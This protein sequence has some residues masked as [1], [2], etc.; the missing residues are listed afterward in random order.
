MLLGSTLEEARQKVGNI[1]SFSELGEFASHPVRTYSSGMRARL[2]FS[3]ALSM[4][5]GVLLID[6]ALAV[7]DAKFKAKSEKAI[8]EKVTSSQTVVMVSHSAGQIN[9]LCDRAVWIEKGEIMMVGKSDLVT[10]KY[11]EAIK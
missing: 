11:T 9:R 1:I 6:E 10:Q 4:K 5:A 8:V 7:G 3:V 2:G